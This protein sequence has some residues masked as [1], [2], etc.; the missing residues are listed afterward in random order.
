MQKPD[1]N[2][3]QKSTKRVKKHFPIEEVRKTP[4]Y[5][6]ITPEEYDKLMKDAKTLSLLTLEAFMK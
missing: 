4:K 6:D 5:E 2:G 1:K 3:I